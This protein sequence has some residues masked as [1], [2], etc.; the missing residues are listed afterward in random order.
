MVPPAS[1][2]VELDRAAFAAISRQARGPFMDWL[3]PRI[4]DLGLGWV[5]ALLVLGAAVALGVLGRE[6]AWPDAL[7]G[8]RRAIA[9]RRG[10]VFPALSALALAGLASTVAKNTLSRDRP[11]W[12]Y[13]KEHAAG[14]ARSV[15]VPVVE[16][17][18]PLKVRSFPSG[19]TATT[20]ALASVLTVLAGRR[21]RLV[22]ALWIG[23]LLIA[24][25]RIYLSSHWPLDIVGGAALGAAAGTL[26][27]RAARRQHAARAPAAGGTIG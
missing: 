21:R 6:I 26:V 23:T 16:G 7:A 27:A 10:W 8:A 2:L 11:W 4:T 19:H 24:W 1:W 25:S 5:Q 15:T 12:F 13:A 3:M 9:R 14:R 22:A 18:Y 17:V 20:V